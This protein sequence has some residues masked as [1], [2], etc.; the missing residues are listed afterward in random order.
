LL[1]KGEGKKGGGPHFKKEGRT[2]VERSERHVVS[3]DAGKE[4]KWEV[5]EWERKTSLSKKKKG[6]HF[7]LTNARKMR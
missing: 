7:V 3:C 1:G 4:K 6:D 2:W 5:V